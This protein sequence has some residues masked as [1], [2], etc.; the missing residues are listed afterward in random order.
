MWFFDGEFVVDR[1]HNVVFIA[2]FSGSENL[3]LLSDYFS[4]IPILGI[5]FAEIV[6]TCFETRLR[7]VLSTPNE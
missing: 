1:V 3:P 4:G 6:L 5:W 2:T 7:L